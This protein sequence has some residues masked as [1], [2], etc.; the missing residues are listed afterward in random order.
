MQPM[1][2]N[3]TYPELFLKAVNHVLKIEGGYVDDPSD[4]GGETNYGISKRQYPHI[5]I[6]ALTVDGAIALYYRDYWQAYGCGELPPVIG[7]FLF[8][9]VV[10]H[11]PK[12]AIKFL[13]NAYRVSVDGIF[14][15]ET[16]GAIK[17]FS[18]NPDYVDN[19]LT[20]SLA[21]RAD[22]YHDLAVENPSQERFIMGWMRRLFVLQQFIN[23]EVTHGAD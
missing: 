17:R 4:A 21:Y 16:L 9:S 3:K 14:G 22:F 20:L 5:N 12:T 19:K 10:N 11:R 8:D 6:R 18:N 1:D 2:T 15:P 7:C 13:Q 23:T